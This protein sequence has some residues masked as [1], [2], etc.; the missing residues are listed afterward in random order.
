[1]LRGLGRSTSLRNG[2]VPLY[3]ILW[4]KY[5]T[6][7]IATRLQWAS[8][9]SKSSREL[10]RRLQCIISL[11]GTCAKIPSLGRMKGPLLRLPCLYQRTFDTRTV[12]SWTKPATVRI[13]WSRW[14]LQH[15]FYMC[16]KQSM[17]CFWSR[18]HFVSEQS[19]V[20][21]LSTSSS[22]LPAPAALPPLCRRYHSEPDHSQFA[23]RQLAM[24]AQTNI[25]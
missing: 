4:N 18:L 23:L 5:G 1:M 11:S 14:F 21:I 2:G 25:T 20:C 15:K 17:L 10:M 7:S 12:Y 16:R 22:T 3:S 19:A 13:S 24:V 6:S 8:T 9:K